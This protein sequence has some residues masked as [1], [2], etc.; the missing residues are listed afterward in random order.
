ML[1]LVYQVIIKALMK[2]NSSLLYSF[3]LLVGDF[4]SLVAAFILAY[5]IRVKLDTR[6]LPAQVP[7]HTYLLIF[8]IL[9]P[10]WLM[11]FGFLNMYT[12]EVYENRFS[13]AARIAIGSFIGTLFLLSSGYVLDRT[14]FPAR[15]VPVY[16]FIISMLLVLLSRTIL[17]AVRRS[18]FA[19]GIGVNNVL[20]VGGTPITSE[21]YHSLSHTGITGYSVVGVVGGRHHFEDIPSK[22]QFSIFAEAIESFKNLSV[23]SVVQSELFAD[24]EKN[25][26][27]LS[28]AQEHHMSYRFVPGNNDV[29][30][31]KVDVGLL[32]NIP[33]VSVHQTALVGW[34]RIAKRLLDIVISVVGIILSSPIMLLIVVYLVIF[35]GGDVILRQKRL[36]RFNTTFNI[37]KLR[38]HKHKYN[39]L[40]P[41]DAFAKMGRPDLFAKFSKNGNFLL[42]DPRIGK[43]GNFLRATSL[44]ELPQL[45]NILK[46]D[47]SLVGPRALIARDLEEYP[48]KNLILSVKSGLTGLAQISGRNNIPVEER[49]KLDIYY[50]QNWSF[51]FDIVILLKTFVQV[52][53]RIIERRVD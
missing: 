21:L 3:I 19:H 49:R 32:Q 2:N 45:F 43:F 37:Y 18:L 36:T 46:G 42:N 44:D 7:A 9:L 23:H 4:I 30:V 17:R 51:W 41:V 20:L 35:D 31:G 28:Y 14:I 29:F 38:T 33:V 13:E 24:N 6:P 53:K 1:T 52:L 5:I 10:F 27:I 8:L 34:G 16:G 12:S 47:I 25:D 15:L 39:G 11:I 48:F 22:K 40:D 26:E 50:V